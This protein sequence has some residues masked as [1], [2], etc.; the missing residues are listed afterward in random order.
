MKWWEKNPGKPR[1]FPEAHSDGDIE[2][3]G[4]EQAAKHSAI[5]NAIE[6]KPGKRRREEVD[7][8]ENEPQSKQQR[9]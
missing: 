3:G 4:V 8:S 1:L 2:M 5:M 6:Q 7:D 9:A